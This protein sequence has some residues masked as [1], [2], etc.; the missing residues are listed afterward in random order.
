MHPFKDDKVLLSWNG[1]MIAALAHAGKIFQEADMLNAAVKANK[2]IEK[3]MLCQGR[4]M[5]RFTQGETAIKGFL[6]D[7]SFYVFSLIELYGTSGDEEYLRKAEDICDKMI[8]LFLD[9]NHYDFFYEGKDNNELIINIKDTY[10]G[11]MPSGN[12]MAFYSLIA[13]SKHTS[14][15][16]DIIKDLMKYYANE[17]EDYPLGHS[18]YLWAYINKTSYK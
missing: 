17:I 6:E 5:R 3:N 10:D 13:L 12:S 8:E 15:Y 2:F 16:E 4:L 7:Y 9:E 14:K 1:L 18:M 11:A